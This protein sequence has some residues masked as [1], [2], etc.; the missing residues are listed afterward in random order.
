MKTCLD[1]TTHLLNDL[2]THPN[3]VL[4]YH[5]S[6]MVLF[7]HSDALYMTNSKA[8]SQ[9]RGHFFLSSSKSDPNKPPAIKPALNGPILSECS[10]LC[11]MMSSA[12]EA[13][14]A[15]VFTN[16]KKT[17]KCYIKYS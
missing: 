16:A 3:A 6:D 11:H 15:G 1:A 4:C 5:A 10:V 9:V 8:Q 13:E 2:A 17:L 12:A 7:V 14:I